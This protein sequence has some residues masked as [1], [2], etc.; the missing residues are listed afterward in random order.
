MPKLAAL[1]Q[2]QS[3]AKMAYQAIRQSILSGQWK[4]GK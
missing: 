4:I 3:L 2:P 1:K